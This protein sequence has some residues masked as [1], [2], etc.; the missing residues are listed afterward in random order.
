[1]EA[2]AAEQAAQ[3]AV[4][5]WV[6]DRT[7]GEFMG[8]IIKKTT[9]SGLDPAVRDWGEAFPRNDRPG[10]VLVLEREGKIV[11]R[12]GVFLAGRSGPATTDHTFMWNL[13]VPSTGCYG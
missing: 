1:M 5:Q 3:I 6:K 4:G 2:L 10:L 11:A 13:P 7:T 8:K 12:E 9:P